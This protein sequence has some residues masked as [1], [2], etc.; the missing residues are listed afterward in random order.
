MSHL[1]QESKLDELRKSLADLTI[2]LIGLMDQRRKIA[3]SIQSLK[4]PQIGYYR[5]DPRR[6]SE[7]FAQLQ[8]HL[9][10]KSLKELLAFSLLIEEHAQQ[11]EVHTYPAWSSQVHLE[12]PIHE[13]FG[14]VNP[15]LLNIIRPDLMT[16]LTLR[17][18]FK[19]F[20]K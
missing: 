11:G 6:E 15:I 7:I 18:E 10:G 16:Q 19:A 5:F 12:S 2:E 17:E 14:Q 9:V 3:S 13:L 20:I 8:D 4:N 1:S